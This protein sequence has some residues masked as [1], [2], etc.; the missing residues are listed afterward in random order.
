MSE[1]SQNNIY[2]TVIWPVRII[3]V[4]HA[5]NCLIYFLTGALQILLHT[6][7]T[8]AEPDNPARDL[9]T[10]ALEVLNKALHTINEEV[11]K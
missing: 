3:C 1:F 5:P 11:N 2:I 4:K 8:L 6:L 10:S 9:L 7:E